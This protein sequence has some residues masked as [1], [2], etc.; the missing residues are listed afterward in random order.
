MG[1]FVIGAKLE[2]VECYKCKNQV[3]LEGT[4]AWGRNGRRVC[5]GWYLEYKREVTARHRQRQRPEGWQPVHVTR[6]V[7][8]SCDGSQHICTKCQKLK[9]VEDFPLNSE[10]PCGYDPRCKQCR[11]ESRVLRRE[12]NHN[13]ILVRERTS[14]RLARYGITYQQYLDILASQGNKCFLCREIEVGKDVKV[15]CV[16]HDHRC[17]SGPRSC[18]KCVRSLLC[19]GCNKMLGYVEARISLVD[20]LGLREYVDRR[21]LEINYV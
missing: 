20:K 21:A 17:C 3:P 5:E 14:W 4:R 18:G 12:V 10:T 2:T 11:H 15:L 16:D 13:D 8:L 6:H 9:K 7:Q 19:A 1:L